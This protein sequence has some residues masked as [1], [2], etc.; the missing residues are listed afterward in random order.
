M[1]REEFNFLDIGDMVMLNQNPS[2]LLKVAEIAIDERSLNNWRNRG[3][4]DFDRLIKFE[5]NNG[6]HTWDVDYERWEKC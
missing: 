2:V 1:S 5:G 3:Y 6:Y 4:S